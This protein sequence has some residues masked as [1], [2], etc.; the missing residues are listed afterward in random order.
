[1][2]LTPEDPEA[3]VRCVGELT[4]IEAAPRLEAS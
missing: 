4:R 1:V 3:F 2:V